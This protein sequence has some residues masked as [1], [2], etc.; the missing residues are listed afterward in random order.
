[1]RRNRVLRFSAVM[2]LALGVFAAVAQAQ[3][4]LPPPPPPDASAGLSRQVNLTPAEML[5]QTESY[6]SRMDAARLAI[7]RMLETARAQRDVVK[8]LCLNDKLNQIDVAL[9]SARERRQ[10]LE[11]A[12]NRRDA[13][14]ANHELTILNVLHQRTDQLTAEANLCVGKELEDIGTSAVTSSV[15]PDLPQED[16]SEYPSTE[17]IVDP[18][19]CSS[20]FL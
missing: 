19:D 1:M 11:I 10:A 18:P 17:V 20:C 4:F 15:D 8:T 3:P 2:L 16:P 9:R 5:G 14:L 6:L 12:V 13:D 7:R